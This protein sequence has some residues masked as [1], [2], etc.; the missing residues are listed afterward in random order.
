MRSGK[1]ALL[2]CAV[3]SPNVYANN[4]DWGQVDSQEF[5]L[6][7]PGQASWEWLL[8][9][10]K[11]SK[12]LRKG[13]PCLECHETEEK[14]MG[15]ALASGKKMDSDAIAG[16]PGSVTVSIQAAIDADF[17]YLR[18]QWQ[19]PEFS[20][21][22]KM[23][24]NHETKFAVMFDDGRV[25]EAGVAGCW[26]VCHVDV[27]NMPSADGEKRE[28]YTSKSRQ[29]ITQKGGGD[30]YKGVSELKAL[31]DENNFMEFWQARPGKKSMETVSG[32]ILEKRHLHQGQ[33]V[34][35]V[36]EKKDN[37][38]TVEFKRRLKTTGDGLKKLDASTPL[39]IGFAIHDDYTSGR[40][41]YVSFG[42]RLS[43]N[44]EKSDIT[45]KKIH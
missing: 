14:Q 44:G 1:I 42:K 43:L 18:A 9:Q 19:D 24:A 37:V 26:G 33:P 32:Y 12:S 25:K 45:V 29:T 27:A 7:Y 3:V 36:A 31:L 22:K 10:H 4:I 6:F 8:T 40:F 41:H 11:G 2:I 38:W 35:S 5:V 17:L 28:L 13:T 34:T 30:K 23:D 16:K 21:G 39:Q 20:S 15:A